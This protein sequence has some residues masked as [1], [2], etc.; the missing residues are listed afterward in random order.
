MAT[1]RRGFRPLMTLCLLGA[2]ATGP[3][4]H[5]ALEPIVTIE[6]VTEYRLDNGMRVLLFP[7]QS[8][9]TVSVNMTYFV[10]S[11]H[12]GRGE[13]GM[14][15][16]LEHM[17][18]KGTD[19]YDN[20]WSALQGRGANFAGTTWVD[21][22]SYFET[23][24]ASDANLEFALQ[25]EADRMVN[26]RIAAEDLAR[27]MTVIRN[28]FEQSENNTVGKLTE[29]MVS[30]AYV[31]HNYGFTTF[32][33][34]S[35]VERVSIDDL[36]AFYR[37]HYQPDNAVL[38][39]AGQFDVDRTLAWTEQY[40]GRIPRPE[41]VL[42]NTWTQEPV[43]D[44]AR[45]VTLNRVGSIQAT[46][47]VY[48]ICA[49][50]HED[51]A[52]V[53]VLVDI[54][55]A[56]PSGRLNKAMVEADLATSV[57]GFALPT[58][59]PGHMIL[60]ATA[61]IEQDISLAHDVLTDVTETIAEADIAE[62][63]V[64]RAKIKL[65][66]RTNQLLADSSRI[67]LHLG[68]WAAMG[69]WRMLFIHRDRIRDVTV[70]DVRRVAQR[71]L[72][73][74]N[75]TSG[76]FTPVEVPARADIPET[77]DVDDLVKDYLGTFRAT[78]EHINART[79]R[80]VLA[81][82][83]KVA[84]L[85]KPAPRDAVVA[86]FTFRFGTEEALTP[87]KTALSLVPSMLMRG[88]KRLGFQ[89]LRDEIDNLGSTI[90]VYGG[91]GAFG[92]SI[93]SDRENFAASVELLAEILQDPAFP[94]EAFEIVKRERLGQLGSAMTDPQQRVLRALTRAMNPYAAGTF[95]YE[96]TIE[97]QMELTEA[98]TIDEIRSLY[99]RFYGASNV[100][101]AV[102]GDAALATG[103]GIIEFSLLFTLWSFVGLLVLPTVSRRGVAEV[104]DRLREND[105]RTSLIDETLRRLDGMQDAETSRPALSET[106]FHPVPSVDRRTQI[107]TARPSG[108]WDAARTT[109]FISAA[110][111]G[112]LGRAVHCNCGRPALW[113][114]L[115]AD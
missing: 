47:A 49:G 36:R 12:E 52:A 78:P 55:T 59:E 101:V 91:A 104:D 15:H 83:M 46:G 53:Q 25:M 82:G 105:A 33:N 113:V 99:D 24:P 11:R 63:E 67:G 77:P 1:P 97:E 22:T 100:E 96:P 39:V 61:R 26:S 75:R 64:E 102:V 80:A 35:D 32:G 81:N 65:L 27:E 41:R 109:V 29:R 20:I 10:G 51:Y 28:E 60:M 93:V 13:K 88:T 54:L 79:T 73:E 9:P 107:T 72:V 38:V 98:V 94:D 58:A 4:A 21:R 85:R 44:G 31:W 103:A 62:T 86:N 74:S 14:A 8:R 2:V 76:T 48:H 111:L 37:K 42:E 114:F 69:D 50:T 68:E 57:N 108:A 92:A 40:F 17:L 56:Q 112:L 90:N 95:H 87:H 23:L 89:A 34:R 66:R 45:F 106:I 71:Y 84:L 5:A 30:A 70:E 16:L 6:G 115:P 7:D 110:G 19:T 43:Q 18:F 3:A